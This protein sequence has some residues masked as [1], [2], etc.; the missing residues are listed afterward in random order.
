[1]YASP[2]SLSS[3]ISEVQ[4]YQRVLAAEERLLTAAQQ[5]FAENAYVWSEQC[6]VAGQVVKVV[7]EAVQSL[8]KILANTEKLPRSVVPYRHLPLITFQFMDE[9]VQEVL[10]LL[11]SYRQPG[12]I[13]MR[14]EERLRKRIAAQ[15]KMLSQDCSEGVRSVEELYKRARQ[16]ELNR[17]RAALS[18]SKRKYIRTQHEPFLQVVREDDL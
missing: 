3:F 12:R 16:A 11:S 13:S 8:Y 18:G 1:M 14:E 6:R 2:M 4:R 5:T 9:Q 15:L 10:P 17:G 7:G